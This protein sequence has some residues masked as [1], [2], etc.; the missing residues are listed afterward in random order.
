MTVREVGAGAGVEGPSSGPPAV[1]SSRLAV[2]GGDPA[3]TAPAPHFRWP[4]ITDATRQAVLRQ[5]DDAISIYDRSGVV[6]RLEQRLEAEVGVP[7][8]LLFNTGT[9][10]LF[11]MFVGAGVGPGD[12]VLCPDYTFFASNSPL[13]FTGAVPVLVD[14]D[15]SG[16]MDPERARELVSERTKAVVVTHVWGVPCDMDRLVDLCRERGLLLLE[17]ISHAYGAT[18]R[19]RPMGT[20]GHAAALSLQAQKTVSGGEGGVLL[21]RDDDLF[22]RALA[23]GHYGRRCLQEIPAEHPLHRYGITGLGLKLRIHPLAAAI[24]EQQLDALPEVLAGRRRVARIL[25]GELG[26]M[27]GIE[28]PP[29]PEPAAPSW[30]GLIFHLARELFDR[31]GDEVFVALL[32]EGCSALDHPKVTAP[33]H[34][35]PLFHEPGAHFRGYTAPPARSFPAAEDFWARGWKLP[36]WHRAEDDALVEQYLA[37]IRKV[38]R[39]FA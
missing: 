13:Y 23:L 36:V 21:T 34:R 11:A 4:L 22:Y 30:Y 17:D 39:H 32:A 6:A 28:L 9:S 38:M 10:A 27:P 33:V 14:C 16:G 5:L 18:W 20:F 25:R 3:V 2:H 35:L 8:A 15:R 12:E 31:Q 37:A 26:A 24:A 29:I 1:A 7:H 19:G